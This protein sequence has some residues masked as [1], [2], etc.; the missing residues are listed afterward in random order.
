MA[1]SDATAI[2]DN[3][4][5]CKGEYEGKEVLGIKLN[6]NKRYMTLGNEATLMSLAFRLYD[7][8]H[9][10][11]KKEDIGITMALVPTK[12]KGVTHGRRHYPIGLAFA[13]GPLQGKDVFIPI[14][15]IIGGKEGAGR[16]WEMLTQVLAT[17]RATSLP[18]GAIGAAK[19]CFYTTTLYTGIRKQFGL[20][21]GKF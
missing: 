10:L 20:S 16:A 7:P 11:G 9:L 6:F 15:N 13:N 1:G 21:V 18:T 5:V 19:F 2:E 12:L 17:G 8:D 14:E 3:G 4:V